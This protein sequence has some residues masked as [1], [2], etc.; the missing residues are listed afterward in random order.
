MGSHGIASLPLHP[1]QT[2]LY[3]TSDL[4]AFC[5]KIVVRTAF[6]PLLG[7]WSVVSSLLGLISQTVGISTSSIDCEVPIQPNHLIGCLHNMFCLSLHF[8]YSCDL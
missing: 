4:A 3:L 1:V 2:Y 7:T 6:W 8:L 5:D